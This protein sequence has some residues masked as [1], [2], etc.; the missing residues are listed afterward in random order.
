MVSH[1]QATFTA[2]LRQQFESILIFIFKLILKLRWFEG[3]GLP[4]N[5]GKSGYSKKQ[6]I[7]QKIWGPEGFGKKSKSR[8]TI[9]CKTWGYQELL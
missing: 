7:R 1:T 5:S 6:D 9:Y 4:G 3:I 8:K 2:T